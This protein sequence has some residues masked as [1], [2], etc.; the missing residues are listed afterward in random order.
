[1]NSLVEIINKVYSLNCTIEAFE[2]PASI[3]KTL[4]RSRDL[5]VSSLNVK[6]L[7]EQVQELRNFFLT[8]KAAEIA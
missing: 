2:T 1:M 5:M 6:D 3:D 7:M 4:Q 8:M